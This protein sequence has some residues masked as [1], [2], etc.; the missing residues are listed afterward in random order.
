M[1]E[2]TNKLIMGTIYIIIMILSIWR[3]L[4]VSKNPPIFL[5]LTF[6]NIFFVELMNL[7]TSRLKNEILYS[8]VI[9]TALTLVLWIIEFEYIDLPA[10][11]QLLLLIASVLFLLLNWLNILDRKVYLKNKV[12]IW[13]FLS[14]YLILSLFVLTMNIINGF[15]IFINIMIF[16]IVPIVYY[17]RNR[18]RIVG[19]M[20]Y[21]K[22]IFIFLILSWAICVFVLFYYFFVLRENIA[23]NIFRFLIIFLSIQNLLQNIFIVN[24]IG[25]KSRAF[26]LIIFEIFILMGGYVFNLFSIALGV[27]FVINIFEF[28]RNLSFRGAYTDYRDFVNRLGDEN[29]YNKEIADYFH[30]DILQDIIFLKREID[31]KRILQED[32]SEK[33]SLLISNIREKIDGLLPNINN[34]LSLY[35]NILFVIKQIEYR[36]RNKD[37]NFDIFCLKEIYLESPYDNLLIKI[38]KE[39]VNNIYK[40]TDSNFAELRIDIRGRSLRIFVSNDVGNFDKESFY[41]SGRF[42]GLKQIDRHISLLG[43]KMNIKNEEGVK[44]YINI[45]LKGREI[46][47]NSI[48]RRS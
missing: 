12:G 27:I 24:Y 21:K 20:E 30:D 41:G 35:E 44:F 26:T 19:F 3:F 15:Y 34:S 42:S 40:H 1:K 43:G 25:I 22:N 6:V 48:G 8:L 28:I 31:E 16:I 7:F 18:K 45:P 33:L 38:V 11:I 47:E 10:I 2:K 37:I 9:S 23:A 17:L 32:V 4:G 46:F 36:Y 5:V 13:I 39:L 29:L 14:F